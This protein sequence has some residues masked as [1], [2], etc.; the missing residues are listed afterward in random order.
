MKLQFIRARNFRNHPDTTLDCA[1]RCNLLLGDNGQGKTNLLEAIAYLSL[2]KS[3]FGSTDGTVLAIS[4]DSFELEGR[5]LSDVGIESDVQIV[6]SGVD[7]T[8][9]VV[10]NNERVGRFSDLVG[11]FPI[12]VLSPEHHFITLGAPADRRKFLDFVLSQAS[13]SYLLDSLEYRRALRQ[14]N[15]LLQDQRMSYG[16]SST[17]LE[18]WDEE[19]IRFGSRIL[20]GRLEFL[21]SFQ[22]YFQRS[23]AELTE[24][25]EE[26]SIRYVSTV[27]ESAELLDGTVGKQEVERLFREAL[28]DSKPEEARAGMT[29]VG[30]HRDD[31]VFAVNGLDARKYASQGQHKTL[32][33]ALKSAEF[34]YLR[35]RRN[36]TPIMLLDDVFGELDDTRSRLLLK[37]LDSVG[38][39]FVTAARDTVVS[40]V[41]DDRCR[42][43]YVSNGAILQLK[44]S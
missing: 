37:F 15:R 28:G 14:R 43:F 44:L 2:T 18:A 40:D 31:L 20:H 22:P 5:F 33:I 6:Y 38:Q 23:Y 11:L 25:M 35:S 4:K 27:G 34:E 21:K 42:R 19:L 1:D 32:L 13:K 3:V 9:S 17:S 29:L 30:P 12:V 39:T 7:G 8:K 41:P 24:A 26:P 10:L 36:E 16:E